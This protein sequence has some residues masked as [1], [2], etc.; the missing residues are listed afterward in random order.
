LA[1]LFV[2]LSKRKKKVEVQGISRLLFKA[3]NPSIKGF[4]RLRER[5]LPEFD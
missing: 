3:Q 1:K 2:S 5:A 4:F